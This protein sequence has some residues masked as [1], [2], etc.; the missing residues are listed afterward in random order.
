MTEF[1]NNKRPCNLYETFYFLRAFQNPCQSQQNNKEE[2]TELR[3]PEKLLTSLQQALKVFAQ[4]CLKK[5]KQSVEP[6][7]YFL[8]FK[9]KPNVA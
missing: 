1:L 4:D 2:V 3:R 7:C 5:K 9:F 6:L 8:Y